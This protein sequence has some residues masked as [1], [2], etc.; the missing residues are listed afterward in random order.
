MID[1]LKAMYE[2]LKELVESELG[3]EEVRFSCDLT[4]KKLKDCITEKAGK[5]KEEL[6]AR[7][8]HLRLLTST[9]LN[10]LDFGLSACVKKEDF[11][12]SNVY[13]EAEFYVSR[14][15][16]GIWRLNSITIKC[17]PN[18]MKEERLTEIKNC[19]KFFKQSCSKEREEL[20]IEL[21]VIMSEE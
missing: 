10:C 13:K 4:E 7:D 1:R 11:K 21:N 2:E 17:D 12:V 14:D 16:R 5:S 15:E 9:I 19:L 3:K 18:L 20:K 6:I 8:P